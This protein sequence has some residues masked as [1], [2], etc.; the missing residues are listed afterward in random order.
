MNRCFFF[1]PSYFIFSK[2]THKAG[3]FDLNRGCR[4]IKRNIKR[5]KEGRREGK[6]IFG[7]RLKE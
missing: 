4:R 2:I 1:S 3:G 5:R 7:E 6:K